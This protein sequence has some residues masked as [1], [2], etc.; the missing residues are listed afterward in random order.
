MNTTGKI[1]AAAATGAAIGAVIGIL[2]APGKGSET[3]KKIRDESK[4]L[5]DEVKDAIAKGREK[6]NSLKEDIEQTIRE[7]TEQFN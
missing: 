7:K 4:K 2:F 5:T 6:L 3:R 1:I